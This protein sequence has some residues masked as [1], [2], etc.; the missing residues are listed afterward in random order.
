[1]SA[2]LLL[3]AAVTPDLAFDAYGQ[4]AQTA[5]AAYKGAADSL[6]AVVGRIEADCASARTNLLDIAPDRRQATEWVRMTTTLAVTEHVPGLPSAGDGPQA[7]QETSRPTAASSR[8]PKLDAY[9]QCT[10]EQ[11]AKALAQRPY[12]AIEMIAGEA[13]RDCENPLKAAADETVAEMHQP[14]LRQQV[15]L[16]FRRRV[17]ADLTNKI[18]AQRAGRK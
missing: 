11:A 12:A 8:Y 1:M 7:G 13:I 18:S 3:L 6:E 14:A 2:A 15:V 9:R 17:T 4:C 16:D 5:A 10:E